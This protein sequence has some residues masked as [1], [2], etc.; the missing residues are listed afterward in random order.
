MISGCNLVS[1]RF[2]P[3]QSYFFSRYNHIWGWASWRRA[4][5][6]YDVAMAEWPAWRDAGGLSRICGGDRR[7]ETYWRYTLDAAYAGRINTWDY[8]W[9][10][11]CWRQGGLSAL[12]AANQTG[13]L[14][15]GSDST[16]TVGDAPK[17]VLE[18][19]PAL[20]EF[21]L[22]HPGSVERD[23]RA[24]ALIDR[25]VFGIGP[26]K[27]LRLR[28]AAVP[29][30]RNTFRALKLWIRGFARQTS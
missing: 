29:V 3:V 2:Q 23:E 8:Q 24:D 22:A 30:L 13:N 21:P 27:L 18:S 4:W 6:S 20:L 14:G 16:H 9:T 17:Y 19:R 10:F 28:L 7:V 15:F 1:R 25:E 11:A 12:P 26:A 5:S